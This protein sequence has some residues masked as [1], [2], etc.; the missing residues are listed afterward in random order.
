MPRPSPSDERAGTPPRRGT[1]GGQRCSGGAMETFGTSDGP[2][3]SYADWGSGQP[4]A[5]S[6]GWPRTGR[7]Y[8][9]VRPAYP[10][11]RPGTPARC[12]ARGGDGRSPARPRCGLPVIGGAPGAIATS[13]GSW[14]RRWGMQMSRPKTSYDVGR[15]VG[16]LPST[17]I[18]R[19]LSRVLIRIAPEDVQSHRDPDRRSAAVQPRLRH[20][21]SARGR[22]DRGRDRPVG[23]RAVRDARVRPLHP[24]RARERRRLGIPAFLEDHMTEFRDH[25]MRVSTVLPRP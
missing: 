8:C 17:S 6:H 1:H 5:S 13:T 16:S 4:V 20:R 24:R 10:A 14:R 21:P 25:A 19:I 11:R 15:F 23:C 2:Q 9:G 18:N 7:G 22:G 3:I 12:R